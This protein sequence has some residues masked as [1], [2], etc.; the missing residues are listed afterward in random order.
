MSFRIS[1]ETP[2]QNPAPVLQAAVLDKPKPVARNEM[3]GG[4][5]ERTSMSKRPLL[6]RKEKLKITGLM[7]TQRRSCPV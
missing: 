6:L 3:E 5:E 2:K 7:H 4:F 1:E